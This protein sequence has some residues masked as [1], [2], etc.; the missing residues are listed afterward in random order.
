M[1][2]KP[3]LLLILIISCCLRVGAQG[4]FYDAGAIQKI[5]V[6]F[7]QPN[8]DFMLDTSRYGVDGYVMAEWAKVNGVQFDSVG[9]K[10]KG[11]SSYDSTF[12]KNPIHI[13]L[14]YLKDQSYQGV[15]D[16][17]LSNGYGD[18]SA[19]REVLSYDILKKYMHCPQSN[20]AQLYING[21]YIGLYSNDESINKSFCSTHF[22]SSKNTFIKCNPVVI[23][24][25]TTKSNLRYLQPDSS[26]YFNFYEMKSDYGWNDLVQLCDT[27]TNHVSA[28]GNNIN[29]DRVLWML[30]F[31]SMLVNLDSY[32]GVFCQNYYLYKDNTGRFN[33]VVWD[34]NMSFG[35]FPYVGS[36]NSS[37]A[38]LTVTNMQQLSPVFHA[39]DPYW[40]LINAVMNNSSYRK[41]YFAHARTIVSENFSNGN[42]LAIAGQLRNLVDTA[43][44]SDANSFFTYNQFQ[45]AMNTD[46]PVFSYTVPGI[47]NLVS[48]RLSYL[49]THVEFN[50]VPPA[51][52]G[53]TPSTVNP[54]LGSSVTIT[55]EV[56]NADPASVFLGLRH[57][58]ED[59]FERILMYDDGLHND[60]AAGDH[61]Y[62]AD[63]DITTLITYYYVYAENGSAGM[64]APERAEHEFFTLHVAVSTPTAGQVVINE[65]LASNQSDATNETG[66]HA[67]W[68]ELFNNTSTPFS[69]YGLYLSDSY[70]NPSKFAF[71]Q[72]ATIPANGYL[73]LWADENN[74]TSSYLHCNFKLS[75]SGEQLMLSDGM[76][77]I[78]DS[79]TFGA[80][81]TDVSYGRCPNGTGSFG[82]LSPT[83][84]ASANCAPSPS[85]DTPWTDVTIM[86]FPNPASDEFSWTWKDDSTLVSISVTDCLG[87]Q[88]KTI[89]PIGSSNRVN[90]SSLGAGFYHVIFTDNKNN[91]KVFRLIKY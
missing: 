47:S 6:Y 73:M 86:I 42:Y 67:D 63:M 30:A 1:T 82:F 24:G 46:Y 15:V 41:Q 17:K 51:I 18:P 50:S 77:N 3:S 22:Y 91:R 75:A 23:P 44:Q 70:S 87:K 62:G 72:S 58:V 34:L 71:P 49:Q 10:Y 88:I 14:D 55:A 32:T 19:I 83:S 76:G 33:P 20:F 39:T 13:E 85:P 69:L 61:I 38:G 9:V 11:N 5:E 40:P 21:D 78:I 31:N 37:L 2:A 43:V 4:S 53:V 59:N 48:G 79:I 89:V 60:G 81:I 90:I 54:A 35:G 12:K 80:Q 45:N 27:V 16:I 64:F 25:P 56:T 52:S 74:S 68:I 84:F 36:G 28:I 7:S 65:F 26:A 8:W 57:N 29:M 66:A